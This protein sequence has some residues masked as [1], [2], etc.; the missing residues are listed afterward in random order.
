ML[1]QAFMRKY[2]PKS[3]FDIERFEKEDEGYLLKLSRP[4]KPYS[5]K[6]LNKEK[7]D[8]FIQDVLTNRRMSS[9]LYD[10]NAT[11][12]I[13]SSQKLIKN[14]QV[15]NSKYLKQEQEKIESSVVKKR[16]RKEAYVQMR[17][18]IDDFE[19]K[20]HKYIK[21]LL[22]TNFK[23]YLKMKEELQHSQNDLYKRIKE[24]RIE[25]FK[26]AIDDIKMKFDD[27][28]GKTTETE[29]YYDEES[30]INKNS[31]NYYLF[32]NNFIKCS[33]KIHIPKIKFKI[34]DVYSRLYN[35]KV[36]LTSKTEKNIKKNNIFKPTRHQIRAKSKILS[37]LSAQNIQQQFMNKTKFKIKNVFKANGGKE[38]TIKVT[39]EM[40]KKCLDKYSGGPETIPNLKEDIINLIQEKKIDVDG[41]VNF[42]ELV[43]KKTGDSYLHNATKGNYYELVR[44][45]I[46]KGSNINKQNLDGDTPM[47]IAARNKNMKIIKLLLDNKAKLDIPNKEGEIAFDFFSFDMKK[48]FGLE[49]KLIINPIKGR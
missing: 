17:T 35:N 5:I 47:H 13:K 16:S 33:H 46:L 6:S 45:F 19:N 30:P 12:E 37:A 18:E 14:F 28:N 42:Y 27:N 24:E 23:K 11:I 48:K 49:T 25:S 39:N 21:N 34:K 20:K 36:L 41:F 32:R 15:Q 7:L 31:E 38:F 40:F 43:E 10:S 26:K 8:K 29:L 1:R 22:K 3:K 4:L 9:I 44:Y 2:R